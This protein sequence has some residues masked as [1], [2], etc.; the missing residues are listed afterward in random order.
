VRNCCCRRCA[1]RFGAPVTCAASARGHS[2]PL[3]QSPRLT[4][5][6]PSQ[7][8]ASASF[9]STNTTLASTAGQPKLSSCARRLSPVARR[10]SPVDHAARPHQSCHAAFAGSPVVP[11]RA[12]VCVHAARLARSAHVRYA[13]ARYN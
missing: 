12:S 1:S 6:N 8:T 9:G 3:V 10:P 13:C 7:P 2:A 4:H 5:P 11:S